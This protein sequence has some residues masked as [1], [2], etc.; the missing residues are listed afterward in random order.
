MF[1]KKSL[2]LIFLLPLLVIACS[3]STPQTGNENQS[4]QP[5]EEARADGSKVVKAEG[6]VAV[7]P[8][9]PPP[10]APTPQPAV[11]PANAPKLLLPVTSANYGKVK[12]D[13]TLVRT[14]DIK[15]T[16]KSPLNIESVSPS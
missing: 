6:T 16:G 7:I 14:F 2:L 10:V 9:T 12:T 5:P 4:N 13:K 8:P 3:S 15:N 1:K 11:A